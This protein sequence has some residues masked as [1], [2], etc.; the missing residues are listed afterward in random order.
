MKTNFLAKLFLMSI[1]CI[2]LYSC[3]SD[4]I[5]VTTKKNVL[6]KTGDAL[7]DGQP[8]IPNPK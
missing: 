5:E 4:N 1:V 8:K 2:S 6:M 7:D 3:T